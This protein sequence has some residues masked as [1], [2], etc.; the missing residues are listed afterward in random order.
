MCTA[1]LRQTPAGPS[2]KKSRLAAF[3]LWSGSAHVDLRCR[4][5]AFKQVIQ[6][7]EADRLQNDIAQALEKYRIGTLHKETFVLIRLKR[8]VGA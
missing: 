2:A 5:T 7:L 3:R 4:R 8:V 1:P 6:L